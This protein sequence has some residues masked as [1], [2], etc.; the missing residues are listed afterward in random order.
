LQAERSDCQALLNSNNNMKWEIEMDSISTT[1]LQ[2]LNHG[3][4]LSDEVISF[5]FKL[6]AKRDAELTAENPGRKRS[7][8]FNSFF[9]AKLIDDDN[10]YKYSNVKRWGKKAPGGNV[11]LLDKVIVPCNL[12]NSHWTCI[13]AFLKEKK[14]QYYDSF[15]GQGNRYLNALLQY[16]EDEAKKHGTPFDRDEW[17]LVPTDLHKTPQQQNGYDCGVFTCTCADFLSVGLAGLDFS[18][19]DIREQRLRFVHK[20]TMGSLT[21]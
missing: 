14:I 8:F 3:C 6:L 2:T 19:P 10:G 20:I 7:H 17:E 18:Q 13:C 21:A 11:L 12:G 1:N 5:Y 15:A 9:F 4:W 16:L